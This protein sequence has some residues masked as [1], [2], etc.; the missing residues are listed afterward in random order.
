MIKGVVFDIDDTLYLEQDYV[1]SGFAEVGHYIGN[2]AGIN[3]GEVFRYLWKSYLNGIRSNTFNHLLDD[4]PVLGSQ[5]EI[6]E[7][8]EVYRAHLPE[9]AILPDALRLL[10]SLRKSGYRLGVIS[11][12]FVTSQQAKASALGLETLVDT[13]QLTDKW[14]RDFW[15]PHPRAYETCASELQLSHS[16]L[17]Y[18][19]DNT[20]KDFI[21]PN[22]LGWLTIKINIPG[23]QYSSLN[24]A[25]LHQKP[26][27]SIR[28]FNEVLSIINGKTP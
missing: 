12:G 15:K 5:F 10:V 23:Q 1:K 11:D 22:Q 8:V 7:L 27:Y 6:P 14:G 21:A 17:C 2:K 3:Q 16:E 18:I 19:A 25:S 9:I 28:N 4:Y 20:D 13:I 26:D 24:V